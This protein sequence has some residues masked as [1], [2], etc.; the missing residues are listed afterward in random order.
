MLAVQRAP[1]TLVRYDSRTATGW[2]PRS[3]SWPSFFSWMRVTSSARM[4]RSMMMGAASSESCTHTAQTAGWPT[5]LTG[6]GPG[7]ERQSARSSATSVTMGGVLAPQVM[8]HRAELRA[9]RRAPY[10]AGVVHD[11]G[12]AAAQENLAGVLVHGALGV[13]DVGHVLDDHHVVGVLAGAAWRGRGG[14]GWVEPWAGCANYGCHV[15]RAQT[16]AGGHWL[17]HTGA[18]EAARGVGVGA[19]PVTEG[20]QC[21]LRQ[22]CRTP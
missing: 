17:V 8:A 1:P 6:E 12:V 13:G 9:R 21:V 4:T 3:S 19:G 20:L 18:Q 2:K 15:V 7:G 16:L 14:T 5:G 11:D 10:L 22:A